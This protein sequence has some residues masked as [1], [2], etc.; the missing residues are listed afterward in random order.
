MEQMPIN[1][2]FADSRDLQTVRR[3]L[4]LPLQVGEGVDVDPQ[5]MREIFVRELNLLQRFQ[6]ESLPLGADQ[7]TE[8]N[9]ALKHGEVSVPALVELAKQYN[10]DGV[11]VG[12]ITS[13]KPYLPPH[14]G[15][16]ARMFSLHTGSWVWIADA[17]FDTNSASCMQDVRHYAATA[18][19]AG[20]YEEDPA[21]L[22]LLGPRRFAAYA[23]HRLVGTWRRS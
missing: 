13:Y 5:M 2:Y 14:V 21:R 8:I 9:R 3:I 11:V 4:V 1:H 19:E 18:V 17:T 23:C 6:V 16:E 22:I 20:D 15:L 7:E 12:R 10:I